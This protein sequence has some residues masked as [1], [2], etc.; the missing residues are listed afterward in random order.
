MHPVKP[1]ATIVNTYADSI[2]ARFDSRPT[3]D[4]KMELLMQQ[5]YVHLNLMCPYELWAELRR[6]RHPKLEPMTFNAK[7]MKPMPERLRYPTD[8]QKTNPDNYATVKSQDNF[9][10]PIFWVPANLRTVN[11]YWDNYNYQ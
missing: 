9:T 10:T 8:E 7:V 3:T 6:T 5:K 11:P 2:A 4:D 1:S